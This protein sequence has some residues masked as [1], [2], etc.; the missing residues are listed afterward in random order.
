MLVYIQLSLTN[1]R[2]CIAFPVETRKQFQTHQ[3]YFCSKLFPHI[4][5]HGHM[6]LNGTMTEW[7]RVICLIGI[8]WF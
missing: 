4:I 6:R 1:Q 3:S 5:S 7:T 2:Q 8:S